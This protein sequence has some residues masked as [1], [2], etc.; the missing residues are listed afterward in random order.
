MLPW[1]WLL[2]GQVTVVGVDGRLVYESL[3]LPDNQVADYNTR[4]SGITKKDLGE[5]WNSIHNKRFGNIGFSA[6]VN[7]VDLGT[8]F[9]KMHSHPSP[10]PPR[11]IQAMPERMHF[12]Q[13]WKDDNFIICNCLCY[14]TC[15]W[16]DYFFEV[17]NIEIMGNHLNS[18]LDWMFKWRYSVQKFWRLLYFFSSLRTL[19]CRGPDVP[20]SHTLGVVSSS[21][22]LLCRQ[23]MFAMFVQVWQGPRS[24]LAAPSL[25]GLPD[26]ITT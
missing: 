10:S 3:V 20:S 16:P 7:V 26:A 12:F 13:F 18:V 4:F 6:K 9:W 8:F 15:M 19:L 21:A 22:P 1:S 2:A 23:K 14:C 25:C 24:L 11:L 17:V 5:R